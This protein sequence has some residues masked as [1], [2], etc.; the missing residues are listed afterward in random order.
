MRTMLSVASGPSLAIITAAA[1]KSWGRRWGYEYDLSTG[2]T[3]TVLV[4]RDDS[5]SPVQLSHGHAGHQ[6]RTEDGDHGCR[7]AFILTDVL[8]GTYTLTVYSS[9]NEPERHREGHRE[10]RGQG[11]PP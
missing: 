4:V 10:R 9:R 11:T 7:G 2:H 5:V 6:H 8:Y 1:F 3:I